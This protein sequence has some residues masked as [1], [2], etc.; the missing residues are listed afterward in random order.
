MTTQRPD[1][2]EKLRKL[3]HERRLS[4]SGLARKIW[5]ET[6]DPRGY[7]V[8]RN[9]DRISA[10]LAGR[11]VPDHENLGRLSDALG[12]QPDDLMPAQDRPSAS[13]RSVY[14]PPEITITS[15]AGAS[16]G[17]VLLQVNKMVSMPVALQ[18]AGILEP[19]GAGD[20]D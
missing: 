16:N 5:G 11:S 4:Q 20:A 10:W 8:A 14:G 2:V 15:V 9:R 19:G 18:V 1:F 6:K 3:M 12:V 7:K 17:M 13:G